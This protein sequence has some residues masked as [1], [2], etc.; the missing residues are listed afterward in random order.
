MGMINYFQYVMIFPLCLYFLIQI[1]QPGPQR[2]PE[3]TVAIIHEQLHCA[4]LGDK[5]GVDKL[6]SE[7][8]V[9]D[10]IAQ[11]WIGIL[12]EKAK[13]MMSTRCTDPKTKDVRLKARIS[14]EGRTQ[15]KDAIRQ[16][17]QMELIDWLVHQPEDQYD[18]IQS[19]MYED[20]P[21]TN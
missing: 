14:A 6:R 8:G 21:L 17:I 11:H 18:Q 3:S 19:G 12:I 10:K 20:M 2:H 9:K 13:V 5:G 1:A 4:A 15:I 16:E 7:T